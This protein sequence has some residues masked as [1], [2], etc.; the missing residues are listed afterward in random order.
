MVVV[1]VD[2]LSTSCSR[3]PKKVAVISQKVAQKLL[4]KSKKVASD[5]KSCSKVAPG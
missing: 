5:N 4:Q 2:V 1:V 3:F